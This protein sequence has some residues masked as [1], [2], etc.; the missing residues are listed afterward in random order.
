MPFLISVSL[1]LYKTKEKTHLI[2]FIIGLFVWLIVFPNAPYLVTDII[3]L[4]ANQNVPF[5]LDITLLFSSA[6]IGLYLGIYSLSHI[7]KILLTWFSQRKTNV[8]ILITILV[9]S[10]GIYMGRFLRW[11]SWDIF[12]QPKIVFKDIAIVLSDIFNYKEAYITT[13]VFFIFITLSYG[14]WKYVRK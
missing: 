3:H 8:I 1:L 2:I 10:F 6:W 14:V 5:W 7:E 13:I 11:N 9:S 12:V 4:G